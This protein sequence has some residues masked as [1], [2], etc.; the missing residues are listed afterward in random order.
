MIDVADGPS[1]IHHPALINGEVTI[2][3]HALSR[4]VASSPGPSTPTLFAELQIACPPQ[5]PLA[6]R[7]LVGHV[8]SGAME[9]RLRLDT[10]WGDV[11]IGSFE[12]ELVVDTMSGSIELD[13]IEGT[14]TADTGSGEVR[15]GRLRGQ[16]VVDTG[17]GDVV[18]ERAD[19][20]RLE[21]DTGSGDVIVRSGRIENMLADTS[22]GDISLSDV[23]F[24]TFTGDAGSGDITIDGSLA[25]A[26][27][28]RADTAS[29]D[30]AITTHADA[31][32][33]LIADVGSGNVEVR[34]DD[35]RLHLDDREIIGAVRGDGHT[36]IIVDTA[37]GDCVIGPAE[38]LRD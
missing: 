35:A 20:E 11:E 38:G 13:E 12:G 7:I 10:A 32:F 23:D 8:H 26:R 18:V 22:S 9:G 14:L 37:S 1:R 2:E 33:R 17:S 29:G 34:F 24:E 36:R 30:V 25:R 6:A 27:D 21:A 3:E 19:A 4:T 5:T 15:I 28:V 16:A 31:S